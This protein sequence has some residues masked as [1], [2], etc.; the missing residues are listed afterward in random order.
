MNDARGNRGQT[1][2]LAVVL[3]TAIVILGVGT[4]GAFYLGT[5]DAGD[6]VSVEWNPSRGCSI[7]WKEGNEPDYWDEV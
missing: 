5:L 7:K 2:G 6:E 3:L 4:F 1:E